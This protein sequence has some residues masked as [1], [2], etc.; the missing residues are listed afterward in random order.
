MKE[1]NP[2]IF[3]TSIKLTETIPLNVYLVK[4]EKELFL[5]DSGIKSM[6][7]DLMDSI[8]KV[9]G[10]LKAIM[11]THSHHDHI[12]GNAQLIE[13]TGCQII[14]PQTHA[15]W[16]YDWDAHYSEFA[17]TFP[18]IFADTAELREEVFSIMDAPHQVDHFCKEGDVYASEN[19]VTLACWMFSG[20]LLEEAG[21]YESKTQ[22]LILGDVVT[23]LDAPFIHGHLTVQGYRDSL[24]KLEKFLDKKPVQQILMAHFSPMSPVEFKALIERATQYLDTIER[25]IIN[26]LKKAPLDLKT[27]WQQTCD[28][29]GKAR[30]FRSLSTVNA[31]IKDLQAK[32]KVSINFEQ[33][34]E[35]HGP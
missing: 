10:K 34:I 19:G 21:W 11:H 24:L 9:G 13:E 27:L 7:R 20:H 14:A 23:L 12:G 3:E 22:T 17:R 28:A 25:T 35:Y 29:L 1:I 15:H 6:H 32:K 30:E 31:H 8:T 4:G 2:Y 5:I 16:H 18:D 33:K 26:Q